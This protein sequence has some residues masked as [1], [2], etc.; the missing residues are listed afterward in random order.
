[1]LTH[2]LLPMTM[3]AQES[4]ILSLYG[5]NGSSVVNLIGELQ[6]ADV[7]I[8]DARVAAEKEFS[9]NKTSQRRLVCP[10]CPNDDEKRFEEDESRGQITC[11]NCGACVRNSTINDTEWVRQYEGDVNPSFHGP[12]P[13]EKFSSSYNLRTAFAVG[14]MQPKSLVKDLAL[15]ASKIDMGESEGN[16]NKEKRTR[17]GYKDKRKMEAYEEF[18]EN[19]DKLQL[20][21]R[22]IERA[23]TLFAQFRQETE[24]VRNANGF[25]AAALIMALREM[26]SR[27]VG[28]KRARTDDDSAQQQ[29]QKLLKFTCPKCQLKFNSN[30]DLRFHDCEGPEQGG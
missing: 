5:V 28:L 17:Q 26:A 19:G 18:K 29:A 2:S 25:K 13:D 30:K 10:A 22:V 27:G 20:H 14:E 1:V 3:A 12:P 7:R 16:A 8:G 15:I 6:A 11:L 24:T 4:G 21:E 9:K 23:A